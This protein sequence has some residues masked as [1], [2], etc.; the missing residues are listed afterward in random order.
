MNQITPIFAAD[1][2][3]QSSR[4]AG[5]PFGVWSAAGRGNAA[6][7][8]DV[9]LSAIVGDYFDAG[10]SRSGISQGDRV[11]FFGEMSMAQADRLSTTVGA[12]GNVVSGNAEDH[13]DADFDAVY[14]VFETQSFEGPVASLRRLQQ[15]LKPG[16]RLTQVV[17]CDAAANPWINTAMEV[18]RRHLPF[19]P[20]PA[21]VTDPFAM[22]DRYMVEAQMGAA[23]FENV[24]FERVD[25]SVR[26][27]DDADA[28]VDFQMNL[29]PV[30]E[31]LRSA[32]PLAEMAAPHMRERLLEQLSP[33]E[34]EDG[35]WMA[36][37]AWV[38]TAEKP[39]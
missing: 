31:M 10:L 6:K 30:R 25:Q 18:A 11:C 16:G 17:W 3:F 21:T 20:E 4:F 27:A 22:A 14:S 9:D 15:M 23:G 33:S 37:S 12:D 39:T 38:V 7:E 1:C 32:G 5:D 13:T 19:N 35:V 8:V 34:T 28:A 2:V 36:S 24:S 26:I 29:P